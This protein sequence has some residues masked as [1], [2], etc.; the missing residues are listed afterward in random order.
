MLP[1]ERAVIGA[2]LIDPVKSLETGLGAADFST[3]MG[4]TIWQAIVNSAAAGAPVDIITLI[5]EL[6]ERYRKV[7]AD[8]MAESFTAANIRG[9]A[10]AVKKDTK[11]RHLGEFLA[12]VNLSGDPD[13]AVGRL[14]GGLIEMNRSDRVTSTTMREL[15]ARMVVE[16]DC[17]AERASRG[18]SVGVPTG[19]H[20]VDRY[21]GGLHRSDL[22][23]V[24]A[25][26]AVGKTAWMLSVALNAARAG[27]KVGIVSAEMAA[28]Q[29]G[30]RALSGASGVASHK[31]RNGHFS[32]AELG[33]ITQAMAKLAALPIRIM[34]PD[35]C[36]PSDV[37]MQAHVWAASGLDLLAV[38][39]LQLLSPDRRDPNRAREVG[40]MAKHLKSIAKALNIPV[41]TLAQLS[42]KCEERGDKRP[43]MADIRDSGEVE[44]ASDQVLFLY[45]DCVYNQSAD[46]YGA[47][48]IIGK[49]RHGPIGHIAMAYLPERLLWCDPDLRHVA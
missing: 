8:L 9:Y 25:R 38:D 1:T 31:L 6:G 42:R 15:M 32:D 7:L 37:L 45:R 24:A 48:I 2:A 22:I 35:R 28:L 5:A 29:L 39:Y 19:F 12:S 21:L 30:S 10:L 13:E 44:E 4:G 16:I 40:E 34:D 41:V 26:P 43:M 47:E 36:R 27:H 20:G 33:A 3:A 49:N 14:L 17:A 11:R 18:E 46:P 23:T